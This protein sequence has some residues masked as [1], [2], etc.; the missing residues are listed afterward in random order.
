MPLTTCV[1]SGTVYDVNGAVAPNAQLYLK[2]TIKSG[3][4][5]AT[6]PPSSTH[7]ARLGGGSPEIFY[8]DEILANASGIV[9][10]TVPR[11]STAYLEGNVSGFNNGEVALSIPDAATATLESLVPATFPIDVTTYTFLSL[12]DTPDAYTGQ[13]L[14]NVRVNAA[15]TAL[16][17]SAPVDT[18]TIQDALVNFFPDVAPFDWTYDDALNKVTLDIAAATSSQKGLMSAADKALLL[19]ILPSL[20]PTTWAS[21][22][23]SGNP[24]IVSGAE[25]YAP[26]S[27]ILPNGDVWCYVKDSNIEITAWK[28][29]DGGRTFVVQ[30]G[31]VAVISPGP[32]GSF[33][34]VRTSEPFAHYDADTSTIH[35]FYTA[36]KDPESTLNI[37]HAT[38]PLA[39]PT[40]LTKDPAPF[41]LAATINTALEGGTQD[42]RELALHSIVKK[43]GVLHYFGQYLNNGGSSYIWHGTSATYGDVVPVGK[44]IRS[45]HPFYSLAQIPTVF[46][47]PGSNVYLMIYSDGSLY[48]LDEGSNRE[49]KSAY[50]FDLNTWYVNEGIVFGTAA[51]KDTGEGMAVYGGHLLKYGTGNFDEPVI[52]DGKL[53]L[54][55]SGAALAG[56]SAWSYLAYLYP[57][58]AKHPDHRDDFGREWSSASGEIL[59]IRTP[60]VARAQGGQASLGFTQMDDTGNAAAVCFGLNASINPTNG[61]EV[62]FDATKK[63]WLF[64]MTN[65]ASDFAGLTHNGPPSETI[66]RWLGAG[67]QLLR[68][69]GAI[70]KLGANDDVGYGRTAAGVAEINTGTAAAL[71]ALN[72]LELRVSNLKVVGARKTGWTVPTSTLKRNAA[73]FAALTDAEVRQVLA[74]IVN[75]LHASGASGTHG[76][77]TT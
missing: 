23:Y 73:D 13:A 68:K 15:G 59:R 25:S 4:L 69:A 3:V 60:M 44:P 19:G 1:V 40:V 21:E 31:G 20:N 27:I 28:S 58:T 66:V 22:R 57:T 16:E 51:D 8:I 29:T 54:Y 74:A 41:L 34:D 67:H 72:L 50:S 49:F 11:L 5:I 43:D 39:T 36:R 55:Y 37:G 24:I 71:A 63:G 56:A 14:K 70:Y 52:E 42:V 17:F 9:T 10:F 65:T 32:P 26:S 46:K 53:L 48:Q 75:D 62:Y 12:V 7:I 38:A 6:G 18:E 77:L 33:D 2:R 76:L 64:Y 35:V 30:N 61:N 47:L 45:V